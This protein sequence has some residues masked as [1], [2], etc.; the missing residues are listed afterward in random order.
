MGWV[1]SPEN[2]DVMCVQMQAMEEDRRRLA[3]K[4]SAREASAH[5]LMSDKLA[6]L[7]AELAAKDAQLLQGERLPAAR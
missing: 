7:Q 2:D 1:C 4:L 3:D 6:Q 5:S